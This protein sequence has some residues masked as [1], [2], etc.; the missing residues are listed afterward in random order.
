MTGIDQLSAWTKSGPL[1]V[2]VNKVLLENNHNAWL[3]YC[4]WLLLCHISR[5]VRLYEPQS[6][7]DHPSCPFYQRFADSCIKN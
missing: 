1:P 5:A 4:L 3:T 7:K 6:L 2:F